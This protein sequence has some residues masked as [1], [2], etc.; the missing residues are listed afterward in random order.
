MTY[1]DEL[2]PPPAANE[3]QVR[4]VSAWGE[5]AQRDLARLRVGVIGTGSVGGLVA[6]ALARTGFEDVMLIDFDYIEKHNLDRLAYATRADI[7]RLKVEVQARHLAARA[8]ADPS[9]SSPLS[10]RCMR[11]KVSARRSTAMFS[12][13]VLTGHGVGMF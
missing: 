3:E 12:L 1:M 5:D 4:T 2:A 7:G 10:L 6:E 11:R 9:G 13:R 8:T